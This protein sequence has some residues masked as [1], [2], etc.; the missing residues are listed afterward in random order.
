MSGL[1]ERLGAAVEMDALDFDGSSFAEARFGAVRGR[2]ARRRAARSAGIGGAS[3]VGVGAVAFGAGQMPWSGLVLGA[4][5]AGSPS[6]ECTT[7]MPDA[8]AGDVPD[9]A[10]AWT[11][12]GGNSLWT[13]SQEHGTGTLATAHFEGGFLVVTDFDGKQSTVEPGADGTYTIKL[14]GY[15][16]TSTF[17]DGQ[18][19]PVTVAEG[20]TAP[21][22]TAELVAPSSDDGSSPVS[23]AIQ[24]ST[25]GVVL[26]TARMEGANLVVVESAGGTQTLEP[27]GDGTYVVQLAGQE[28]RWA[29][30]IDGQGI[31]TMQVDGES[32][33]SEDIVTVG[34]ATPSITSV[35]SSVPV[36]SVT[37]EPVTPVPSASAS[38]SV[39]PSTSPDGSSEPS[40]ATDVDS[41][42]QCGFVF[43]ADEHGIDDVRAFGAETTDTAIRAVFADW[44]GNQAPTTEVGD[45]GAIAY[46][47]TLDAGALTGA[48][49]TAADPASVRHDVLPNAVGLSFVAV[50]DA[51]VVGVIPTETN[52]ATGLVVDS[53][54]EGGPLEAFLWNTDGLTAC[55]TASVDGADIYAVAGTSDGSAVDY[56]WIKV[57]G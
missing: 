42:F 17:A 15:E 46:H 39:E 14:G 9:L 28:Y 51:M 36:P 10:V 57:S 41:P 18:D 2:V 19:T 45:T 7:S 33:G 24:E 26:A 4:N 32:S 40:P 3:L 12:L 43:D 31:V 20:N 21:V 47:A 6:V 30:T 44:Y 49:V 16:V 27:Q 22:M 23:W 37:C 25:S 48:Q 13:F 5:P 53:D 11:E 52:H 38:P 35:Q 34:S 55:G 54:G 1:Q 29:F 56:S 8:A 50:R